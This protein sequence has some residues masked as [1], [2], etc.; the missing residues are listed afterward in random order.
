MG[1]LL[2]VFAIAWIG[3]YLQN[4]IDFEQWKQ[5]AINKM[6]QE[7]T[8]NA[9]NSKRAAEQAEINDAINR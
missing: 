1:K 7:K 5:D 3:W 6:S 2:L 4:N 8:I 9:V